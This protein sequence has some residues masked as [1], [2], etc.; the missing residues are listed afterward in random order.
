M[1]VNTSL[2]GKTA[3]VT[4]GAR[5]IGA[6]IV[7]A[8]AA[9]GA[10]VALTYSSSEDAAETLVTEIAAAGGKALAIRA[11]NSDADTARQGVR[12]A[13][14]ALGS[15]DI[16]VNN[17]GAGWFEPFTDTTDEHI[18]TTIDLN[19]RGTVYTTQEALKH[20]PDNGRIIT[21]GSSSGKVT[22]FAGG[23]IYGMSKAALV[24]FTKGLARDL[25]ARGITANVIQPGP[26]DTDGNPAD[27]PFGGYLAGLTALNRFGTPADVGGL[28]A[29]I[30]SDAANFMTGESISIDAGWTA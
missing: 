20:L 28:A 2:A 5:G 17:A 6:G 27:G 29:W 12:D 30:A 11:D 14:D 21:I 1:S 3:L 9:E 26:I 19:I 25:G 10:T 13:V 15:L 24:G 23:T 22:L 16:L 8:L 4:G 18:E 7:R